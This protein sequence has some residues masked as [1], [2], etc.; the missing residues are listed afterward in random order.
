MRREQL[1]RY[2]QYLKI[3]IR[4]FTFTRFVNLLRVEKRLFFR[5][6]LTSNIKP[7]FLVVE[8]SNRCNLKCPLCQ[9]GR[10]EVI[11]RDNQMSFENYKKIITPLKNNLF[12]ILLY[13]WGEPFFNK[14]IYKII[15]YN[16]S[17]NIGT[18]IS[19]NLNLNIDA[20]KLIESGLDH[21][22]ISADGHKQDIYEKYRVGGKLSLLENNLKNIV[23]EKK[24]TKSN[25]PYIEW[26]T[27]V[28]KHTE[29]HLTEISK[30]A[31]NM[32][33]NTVRFSNLNFYSTD[34]TQRLK[35]EWLPTDKK[36]RY[37][38][39]DS[40]HAKNRTRKPCFW[41][42]RTAV[43]NTDGEVTP[44][45]LYDTEG[46]GNAFENPIADVW[47]NEIYKEA[48]GRFCGAKKETRKI[49]CDTCFANFLYK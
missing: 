2:Y 42:W 41:L 31:Y 27:L 3:Y 25:L 47:Q 37:F 18:I 40:S 34:A 46:W 26:Q 28:T 38:D 29:K 33:V 19:S 39:K 36:Y 43:I 20:E 14:D 21:L 32:G 8:I 15:S 4:H 45:C 23:K 6:V 17:L 48:R 11:Q 5:Q 1:H 7:Y 22:I 49:I 24:S 9:M 30:F 44:C 10:G 16:K 12:Q 13:N 35:D